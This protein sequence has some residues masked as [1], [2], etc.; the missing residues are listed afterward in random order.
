MNQANAGQPHYGEGAESPPPPQP[1]P[2]IKLEGDSD[3]NTATLQAPPQ[4]DT[5]GHQV[6]LI[7]TNY[8]KH[9]IINF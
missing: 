6:I 1:Q 4:L 7:N 3:S 9:N 5:N 8:Y 2:N